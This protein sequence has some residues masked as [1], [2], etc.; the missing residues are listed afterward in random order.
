MSSS[1]AVHASGIVG[2][3]KRPVLLK[4]IQPECSEKRSCAPVVL[5]AV[6]TKAGSVR[7]AKIAEG[8]TSAC[9]DAAIAALEEWEY[10]PATLNSQ[11]VDVIWKYRVTRCRIAPAD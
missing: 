2:V 1:L 6:I 8:A 4:G 10:Q 11:P 5:E 7:D 3:V 9:A